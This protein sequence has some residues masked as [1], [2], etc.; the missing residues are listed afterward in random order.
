MIDLKTSPRKPGA[1]FMGFIRT[2]GASPNWYDHPQV[3]PPLVK[4]KETFL[5]WGVT[6]SKMRGLQVTYEKNHI[7]IQR[8]V[9]KTSAE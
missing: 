8:V 1:I 2:P 5:L 4:T 7:K 9:I 3:L 6:E